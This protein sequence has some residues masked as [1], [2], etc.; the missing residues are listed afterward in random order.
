MRNK[1]R[2]K[3]I[4][5]KLEKVWRLSPDLR[6]MQ[7]L[8]NIINRDKDSYYIEDEDIEAGLDGFINIINIERR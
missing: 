5:K 8:L 1:K 2:I 7:L 4:L 6:L 3:R